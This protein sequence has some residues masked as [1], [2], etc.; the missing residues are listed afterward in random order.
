MGEWQGRIL[1]V[2]LVSCSWRGSCVRNVPTVYKGEASE[3]LW[4]RFMRRV[5]HDKSGRP[6][7]I[8]LCDVLAMQARY[9]KALSALVFNALAHNG[10]FWAWRVVSMWCYIQV[11]VSFVK[12]RIYYVESYKWSKAHFL[13]FLQRLGFARCSHWSRHASHMHPWEA[14]RWQRSAVERAN[15]T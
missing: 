3:K 15:R 1:F 7:A 10:K 6:A 14:I 5:P 9:G 4:W 11:M 13:I 2:M 8:G 12:R